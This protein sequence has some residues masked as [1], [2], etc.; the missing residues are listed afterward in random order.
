MRE[1]IAIVDEDRVESG[2]SRPASDGGDDAVV[3]SYLHGL[4]HATV[5][6]RADDR[7]VDEFVAHLELAARYPLRHARR[8]SGAAGRTVDGL[9]AVEHRVA[10][11]RAGLQRLPRPHDV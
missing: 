10:R 9:V 1:G 11:G 7:L 8:C 2:L 3:A 6:D 5:E 4:L